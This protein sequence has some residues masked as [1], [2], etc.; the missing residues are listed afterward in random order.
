MGSTIRPN[1]TVWRRKWP[2]VE[3]DCNRNGPFGRKK[4]HNLR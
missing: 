4:A 2:F 3:G 1:A